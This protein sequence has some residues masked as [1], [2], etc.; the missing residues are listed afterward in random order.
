[1]L[2]L[3]I[4][5]VRA[6]TTILKILKIL[7]I[8]NVR[9]VTTILKIPKILKITNVRALTTMGTTA[10]RVFKCFIRAS[11][12]IV[13]SVT[14]VELFIFKTTQIWKFE[15]TNYLQVTSESSQI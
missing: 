2:I 3:K 5:N 12:S 1:M 6:L 11:S 14:S 4:T 8:T 9:A 10:I 7:K 15:I 13:T